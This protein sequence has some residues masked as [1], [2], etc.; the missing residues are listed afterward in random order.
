M[1]FM[2]QKT[3]MKSK[4]QPTMKALSPKLTQLIVITATAALAAKLP[5]RPTALPMAP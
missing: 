4:T 3:T 2:L 5:T 1:A